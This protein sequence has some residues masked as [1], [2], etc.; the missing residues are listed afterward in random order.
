[1]K[2]NERK[3][4]R[5]WNSPDAFQKSAFRLT[6][7]STDSFGEL[8]AQT[9]MVA[10]IAYVRVLI[11]NAIYL[12]RNNNAT[13]N[14][15]KGHNISKSNLDA[16]FVEMVIVPLAGPDCCCPFPEYVKLFSVPLPMYTFEHR[17]ACSNALPVPLE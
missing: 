17:R 4:Q 16:P 6:T 2:L 10:K 14:A 8:S 12:I 11:H 7:S 3:K 9:P 1:M 5:R 13:R 15:V